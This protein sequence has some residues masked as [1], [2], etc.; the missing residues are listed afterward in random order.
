MGIHDLERRRDVVKGLWR[1]NH[2]VGANWVLMEEDCHH[3]V[4]NSEALSL[5]LFNEALTSL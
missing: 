2:Q 5:D 4:H 1:L 3:E